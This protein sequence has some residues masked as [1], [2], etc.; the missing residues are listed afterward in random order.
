[1]PLVPP[2][3]YDSVAAILDAAAD[4]AQVDRG[5]VRAVAWV[6]SN[7]VA[8]AVSPAGAR[9]LMQ[10]MPR[11]AEGLG[12]AIDDPADNAR[13]GARYL[14]SMLQRFHGDETK[15]LAAYNRGPGYIVGTKKSP[16]HPHPE[17]WT[18]EVRAYIRKIRLFRDRGVQP[19]MVA[20]HRPRK[21]EVDPETGSP[22]AC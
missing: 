1:M 21:R 9:G 2:F 16:P 10:L 5:L 7:W 4:Y 8:T 3:D 17:T 6:E 14:A 12:V 13:G 20:Q 22:L 11:T 15:A 19:E 18:P